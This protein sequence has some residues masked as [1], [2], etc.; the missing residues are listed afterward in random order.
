MC[1]VTV[2][3]KPYTASP[4][5]TPK[6][7]LHWAPPPKKPQSGAGFLTKNPA[8]VSDFLGE[9][10][11]VISHDALPPNIREGGTLPPAS[12]GGRAGSTPLFQSLVVLS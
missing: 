9:G 3:D 11:S 2:S 12:T 10:P 4:P 7:T 6:K 8:T 5:H 1:F